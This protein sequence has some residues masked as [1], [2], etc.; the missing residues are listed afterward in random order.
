MT[1]NPESSAV[2][3]NTRLGDGDPDVSPVEHLSVQAMLDLLRQLSSKALTPAR[4]QRAIA[5]LT[6][7]TGFVA[8]F[9]ALVERTLSEKQDQVLYRKTTA[10]HREGIQTFYLAQNVLHPPHCHHNVLST[11]TMLHG[12][13]HARE[14]DR[15]A[16]LSEDT[17][18]MRLSRDAWL[19]P[20]ESIQASEVDRNCHWFGAGDEPAVMLNF[21][22][23]GYQEWTFNP[24]ERAHVRN[25]VDPTFLR[26]PDGMMIAKEIGVTEAYTKFGGRPL[27]DFPAG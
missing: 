2:R 3:I 10:T 4:F 13:I 26:G 20:G 12:Q 25:L 14:Y 24:K 21:H 6:R 23:Y 8:S 27:S 1:T 9:R 22:A 15:I 7:S 17:L 19:G 11:Q 18:L 16:R 5:E